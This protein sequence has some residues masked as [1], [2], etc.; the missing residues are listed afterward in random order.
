MTARILFLDI[1]GVILSGRELHRTRNN[2]YIPP[3]AV[4]LL[5]EVCKRTGCI[6][7][8]SSTWR[9]VEPFVRG[10]LKKAGFSGEFAKDWKTPHGVMVGSLQLS[11]RRGHE[12][13][14]W[15]GRHPEVE[16]YAIIDDDSDMLPEQRPFFVQTHFNDGIQPEHV[17][18]LVKVLL[19]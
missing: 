14:D 4:A 7:V 5:N 2:R 17:E 11:E 1:D 19:P 18:R 12:I 8:I 15:L 9:I 16:R 3:E 6:V 10:M 13:A